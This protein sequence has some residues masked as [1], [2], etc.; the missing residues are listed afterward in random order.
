MNGAAPAARQLRRHNTLTDLRSGGS[1]DGD[2]HQAGVGGEHGVQPAMCC[3]QKCAFHIV[4]YESFQ[5]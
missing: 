5:D 4:F 3:F 1:A 2:A